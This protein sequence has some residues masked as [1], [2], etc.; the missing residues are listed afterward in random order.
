MK[1]NP[2]GTFKDD[3][4]SHFLSLIGTVGLKSVNCSHE[5]D[6]VQNTSWRENEIG[7]DDAQMFFFFLYQEVH[8]HTHVESHDRE[9]EQERYAEIETFLTAWNS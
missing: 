1:K 8:I 6:G 2:Q 4:L 9:T 3:T 7:H 5:R